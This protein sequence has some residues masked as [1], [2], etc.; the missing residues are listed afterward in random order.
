MNF[1]VGNITV[2]L[3]CQQGAAI[4]GCWNVTLIGRKGLNAPPHTL[5]VV[6]EMILNLPPV[7]LLSLFYGSPH[8]G[9]CNAVQ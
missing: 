8:V 7:G 9:S 5:C 3:L 2:Q 6:S 4:G 1:K